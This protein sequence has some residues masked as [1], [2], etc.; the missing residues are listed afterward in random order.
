MEVECERETCYYIDTGISFT[1]KV[2]LKCNP[3]YLEACSYITQYQENCY[4]WEC[5]PHAP[6][7]TYL[8]P[9]MIIIMVICLTLCI[10]GLI[11]TMWKFGWR[12][13]VL[14]CLRL[15]NNSSFP[16]ARYDATGMGAQ[17][18]PSE[19]TAF[20][21]DIPDDEDFEALMW[22]YGSTEHQER[23]AHLFTISLEEEILES[24]C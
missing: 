12:A 1:C 10:T 7:H 20:L 16:L 9:G 8:T 6:T 19:G 15:Q 18:Q 21:S 22:H 4:K 11:W 2:F 23:T 5:W 13:S 24:S 17:D 14:Q 3:C